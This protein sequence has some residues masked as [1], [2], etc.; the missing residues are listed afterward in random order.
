MDSLGFRP[1]TLGRLVHR[2]KVVL[3]DVY[4]IVLGQMS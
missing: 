1:L 4:G 3:V 2:F